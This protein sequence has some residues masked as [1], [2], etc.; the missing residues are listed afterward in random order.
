MATGC[1]VACGNHLATHSTGT[2]H[3]VLAEVDALG[4]SDQ[5]PRA[6]V[7]GPPER[8]SNRDRQQGGVARP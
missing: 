4:A 6:R 2:E 7:Q 8:L 3:P 5:E 1:L